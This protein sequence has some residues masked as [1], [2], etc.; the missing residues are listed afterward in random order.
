M[1]YT[2][3]L[4]I[5]NSTTDTLTVVE[6]ACWHYANGGTWT[7]EQ[8]NGEYVLTM[9]GSGTSGM[10]RFQSSSGDLFTL[11]LGVHNYH[12]WGDV[13]VNLRPEDTAARMLPEYYSGGKYSGDAHGGLMNVVTAR[14]RMVGFVF[15]GTEG[16]DLSAVMFYDVEPDRRV[17]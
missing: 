3:R 15:E 8:Q 16:H 6:E 13:Q 14:Q 1:S 17:Y 10:L 4:S 5:R 2:I 7:A 9:G 11:V 12:P